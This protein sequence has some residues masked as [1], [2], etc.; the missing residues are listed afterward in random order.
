MGTQLPLTAAVMEMMQAL[1][2]DGLALRTIA[3]WRAIT[4]N[5]RKWKSLA[6]RGRP[7]RPVMLAL[8]GTVRLQNYENRRL[9]RLFKESLS[10]S[11]V[12]QAIEKDSE[13]S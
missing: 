3:R 12:A 4:K 2:A 11:E 13:V 6:N 8:R 10:A 9:P 1:R 7:A 5:W